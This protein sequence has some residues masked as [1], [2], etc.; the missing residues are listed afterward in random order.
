MNKNEVILLYKNGNAER[1]NES[2]ISL[3]D[4]RQRRYLMVDTSIMKSEPSRNF[5]LIDSSDYLY[6]TKA[7]VDYQLYASGWDAGNNGESKEILKPANSI[8]PESTEVSICFLDTSKIEPDTGE[9][10]S[11]NKKSS[12]S[13]ETGVSFLPVFIDNIL[14]KSTYA[15]VVYA[16]TV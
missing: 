2:S 14:I 16:I 3:D 11:P 15:I 6:F 8:P 10:I 13:G 9:V 5:V 1:K 4:L 12:N 7:I